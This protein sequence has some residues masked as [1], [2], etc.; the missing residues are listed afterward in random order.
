[1]STA[2]EF[3]KRADGAAQLRI[4]SNR[5]IYQGIFNSDARR[6]SRA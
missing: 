6:L 1:M 5:R 3:L 4:S 2:L